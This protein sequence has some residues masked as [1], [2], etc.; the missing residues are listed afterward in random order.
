MEEANL[1]TK[2]DLVKKLN[3]PEKNLSTGLAKNNIEY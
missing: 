2:K 3:P 1:Y